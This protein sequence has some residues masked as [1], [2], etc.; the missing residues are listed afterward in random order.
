MDIAIGA[1]SG[2][3]SYGIGTALNSF[4]GV[5]GQILSKITI[6]GKTLSSIVP[7]DVFMSG[8]SK[9]FE[10]VG[11]VAFGLFFDNILNQLLDK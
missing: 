1:I 11:G 5:A 6:H 10:I 8:G 4:G 9:L 3:V 7:L 2:L